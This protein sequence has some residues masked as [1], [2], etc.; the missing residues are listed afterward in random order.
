MP[1]PIPGD[2]AALKVVECVPEHF[3]TCDIVFSA[4]DASVAGEIEAEFRKHEFPVFS[5]A[6]N[7][8]M[9]K[10]VPLVVP[11]VNWQHLKDLINYQRKLHNL[12]KGFIVTNANCSTTGLC[13][14]LKPLNDTYGIEH[15][16]VVTM[17][18]ISGAG[19]PGVASLDILGNIVPYISGE[20]D[21]LETEPFKIL[22]K[23]ETDTDGKVHVKE[24]RFIADATCNRVPVVEGHTE[25]VSL[26]FKKPPANIEEVTSLLRSYKPFG[27]SDTEAKI[28]SKL[29]CSPSVAIQVLE[30]NSRPQPRLDLYFENGFGVSVGRLRKS[31]FWHIEFT[32][33]SHN[34]VLGAAG[35]AILNAEICVAQDVIQ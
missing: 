19:Y 24:E 16:N 15:M 4:L 34:T 20:E 18:A 22:G 31:N 3:K 1:T 28:V 23:L 30:G 6:K 7:Y 13:V 25:C 14:A 17:Q 27:N 11:T 32:L 2:I 9:A 8:R 33:L 12:K 29:T 5:N 26:R 21:K 10:D 35:A